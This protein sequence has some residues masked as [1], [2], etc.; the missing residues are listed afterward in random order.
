MDN[1]AYE[2]RTLQEKFVT[3]YRFINHNTNKRLD[4]DIAIT[5]NY[6]DINSQSKIV[7][8]LTLEQ[9][10]QYDYYEEKY[11]SIIKGFTQFGRKID[12]FI[13][14]KSDFFFLEYILNT[15][16]ENE[17]F[18]SYYFFKMM[19]LVEMLIKNPRHSRWLQED[20]NNLVTYIPKEIGNKKD[21]FAK[22]LTQ[23][24]NAIAHANYEKLEKKI[25]E[26][27]EQFMDHYNFDYYKYSRNNWA[28]LNINCLLNEIIAKIIDLYLENK[29]LMLDRRNGK[30][31][32]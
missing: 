11:Q 12:N 13:Q 4:Y 10:G 2:A 23:L 7:S 5:Y 18:N 32:I 1:P 31:N 22:L 20:Y 14:D 8:C 17:E 21:N 6:R 26:Y 9:N 28:F 25:E 29:V 19:T 27:I 24:R 16:N 3:L 30:V 15:I